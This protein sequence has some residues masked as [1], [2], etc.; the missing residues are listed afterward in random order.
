MAAPGRG[1]VPGKAIWAP[2]PLT[3]RPGAGRRVGAAGVPRRRRRGHP[4]GSPM[5]R[6]PC[7]GDLGAG[8][9]W[10]ACGARGGAGRGRVLRPGCPPGGLWLRAEKAG[11]DPSGSR[12]VGWRGRT[13]SPGRSPGSPRPWPGR[14]AVTQRRDGPGAHAAGP[15]R[16]SLPTRSGPRLSVLSPALEQP[17]GAE[18]WISLL[19]PLRESLNPPELQSPHPEIG[20][21]KAPTCQ[22]HWED[23]TS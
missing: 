14:A 3:L 2:P 17:G 7:A 4:R 19:E 5:S 10:A 1:E 12:S 22:G 16:G 21:N 20:G 8:Y 9:G 13:R 11:P 15:R 23:R 18:P 6:C